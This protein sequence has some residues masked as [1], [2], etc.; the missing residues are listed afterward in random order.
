MPSKKA[1]N[2]VDTQIVV[3]QKAE[4][5]NCFLGDSELWS[6]YIRLYMGS[7]WMLLIIMKWNLI[8]FQ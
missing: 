1:L 6:L 8:D 2:M 5:S 3:E 7:I 4:W